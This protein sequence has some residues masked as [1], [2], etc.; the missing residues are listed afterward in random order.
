MR[1]EPITIIPAEK[2]GM[3][4]AKRG[5]LVKVQEDR[6]IF[7][8]GNGDR[9]LNDIR[10]LLKHYG[11]PVCFSAN[12]MQMLSPVANP[13]VLRAI[14]AMPVRYPRSSIPNGFYSWRAFTKR[15]HGMRWNSLSLDKGIAF[16]VKAMSE[17]GILVTG[18]CDGHGKQE[19]RIYFASVWAAAWFCV[20]SERFLSR[21]DLNYEWKVMHST[22]GSICLQAVLGENER[23]TARAICHDTASLAASLRKSATQLRELRRTSFKNRSM[24][25]QAVELS[26]DFDGLCQWMAVLLNEGVKNYA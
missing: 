22:E 7:S 3:A 15:N 6:V 24:R 14:E 10:Q 1:K 9:D 21:Q 18:G 2:M 11:V 16:L 20:V 12:Q 4:L 25:K 13:E 19:P 23:W 26:N 17:A 5:F 8:T